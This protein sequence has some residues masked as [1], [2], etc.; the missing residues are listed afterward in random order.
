MTSRLRRPCGSTWK[1]RAA[2]GS[3]QG[4][5]ARM[6]TP[7]TPCRSGGRGTLLATGEHVNL[8]LASSRALLDAVQLL[9]P[10]GTPTDHAPPPCPDRRAGL[11]T[12]GH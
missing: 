7:Y 12:G 9:P 11:L 1:A 10:T 4:S 6:V 2:R 5:S 8:R 3:G